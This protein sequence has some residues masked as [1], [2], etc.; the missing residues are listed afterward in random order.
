[1]TLQVFVLCFLCIFQQSEEEK[2]IVTL[3]GT[4]AFAEISFGPAWERAFFTATTPDGMVVSDGRWTSKNFPGVARLT[5][6]KNGQSVAYLAIDSTG[7]NSLRVDDRVIEQLDG[8]AGW[9][10]MWPVSLS[11]DGK[12]IAQ[13]FF[14]QKENRFVLSINASRKKETYDQV[15]FPVR[16]SDDGRH[17]AFL[18]HRNDRWMIVVDDTPGKAFDIGTL[19]AMSSDGSVIAYAAGTGGQWA[20]HVGEHS[21]PVSTEVDRVFLSANGKK[22]GFTAVRRPKGELSSYSV[23]VGEN[24]GP[25]FPEINAPVFSEDGKHFAYRAKSR[26]GDLFL[27]LDNKPIKAEG[28]IG[29]PVF[30]PESSKLGYGLQRDRLLFWKSLSI[31]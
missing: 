10:G 9:S 8:S 28:M 4:D 18:A 7:K 5:V 14:N 6:S 23:V 30:N 19:P 17:T 1:M 2:R 11:A 25:E 16:V 13:A 15:A 22:H 21:I 20:L 27:V 29:D 26:D 3:P 24:R 12:T 31:N